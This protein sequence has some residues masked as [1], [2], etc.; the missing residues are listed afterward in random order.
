MAASAWI[1]A[2]CMLMYGTEHFCCRTPLLHRVKRQDL[3]T[4]AGMNKQNEAI[5]RVRF[6]SLSDTIPKSVGLII[7]E[8]EAHGT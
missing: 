1:L 4:L 2:S 6:I 3:I 7:Y 5:I 8:G